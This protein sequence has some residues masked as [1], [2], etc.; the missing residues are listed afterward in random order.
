MGL[1]LAD[2]IALWRHGQ[3]REAERAC[4]AL[5]VGA[6]DPAATRGLLAEIYSSRGHF[7]AAS[8]QLRRVA[9]LRPRDAAVWRRLG[10]A[11]FASADFAAAVQSFRQAIALAPDHPRAHHNLGRALAKLAAP[12]AAIESYRRAIALEPNYASAYNNLG[13]AL[14]E[15]AQIDEALLCYE[16]AAALN[17]KLAEAIGNHGNALFHLG[18]AEESLTYFERALVLSPG[19]ATTLC[20]YGNALLQLRRLAPALSCFERALQ[21]VPDFPTGHLGIGNA[22]RDARRF[23]A[24]LASYERAIAMQPDYLDALISKAGILIDTEQFD[25][26][27]ECC[28]GVLQ[29]RPDYPQALYLRGLALN[30][31]G[32]PHYEEAVKVLGRLWEIAPNLP[33]A[34]GLLVHTSAMIFDW[35]HASRATDAM[36]ATEQDA[37][38]VTPLALLAISDGAELQLQCARSSI[39]TTYPPAAEPIWRGERWQNQK[40]RI[41]YVSGDLRD[42]ALAY[43]MVGVFEQHDRERFE[44]L[45]VSLR[46][47]ANNPFGAR[48]VS[49][50]DV[51]IDVKAQTDQQVAQLLYEMKVDIAVDLMGITRGHRLNI[52]GHRGVPLQVGYLGYPGTSGASYIDYILA[53]SVVIPPESRRFYAE[54]VVYLPDCFQANDDRRIIAENRPGRSDVGLP[55]SA[56]VFCSFNSSYKI[57]PQ[58]F[59]VWCR[60]LHAR[61]S[62][63]LWMLAESG[64][65]QSNLCRE[66]LARGIDPQRLVFAARLPYE[67]HLARL[68]LADLFLDSFPFNAGTTAS[69]ALWAGLPVLTCT[70]E[71]FA[72]RMAT[73]LL[74]AIGLPELITTDITAYEQLALRLSASPEP[75]RTLRERL[76][77]NRATHPLF[78]TVRFCRHLESAYEI[79]H[80]RHLSGQAPCHFSVAPQP[81]TAIAR[82]TVRDG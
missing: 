74:Q 80:Q 5:L 7:A 65:A 71:A 47:P 78:D 38:L 70:G 16:R 46:E 50:F 10:D 37:P 22:L 81:S 39:A 57:T 41:A 61:P 18:R 63:V 33:F 51:F 54:S 25:A 15:T 34:V 31:L 72:A 13:M 75:L 68:G 32:G 69:D 11:Q 4:T 2:A 36:R 53:D 21:L 82:R 29:S 77:V 73:S 12:D 60:L 19:D 20:N 62:S 45:G 49:A 6:R 56:F 17:P 44:I 9:E 40:L 28:A 52:F 3:H 1:R 24:A 43:L 26:A 14:A 58:L 55:P 76:A 79:M 23:D 42:H 30:Y 48:V 59:D 66:A 67:Q 64:I 35:S 8:E 27:I